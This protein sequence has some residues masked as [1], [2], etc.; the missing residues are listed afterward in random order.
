MLA[1][2]DF[3]TARVPAELTLARHVL[4]RN[5]RD[6][7]ILRTRTVVCRAHQSLAVREVVVSVEREETGASEASGRFTDGGKGPRRQ[8]ST[9]GNPSSRGP[10]RP[11]PEAVGGAVAGGVA[12]GMFFGPLGALAGMLVGVA[13][14]VSTTH[15]F[16]I[17]DR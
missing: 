10:W 4:L 3:V 9:D 5:L 1:W 7:M 13:A 15:D 14:A 17:P 12:G 6:T 2:G 16:A 8:A 11:S